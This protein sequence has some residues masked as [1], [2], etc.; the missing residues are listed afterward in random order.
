LSIQN[1]YD[2]SNVHFTASASLFQAAGNQRDQIRALNGLADNLV[3][4]S[5]FSEA[6]SL[7]TGI[8][9]RT[10]LLSGSDSLVISETLLLLSYTA[11]YN[12]RFEFALSSALRSL[13]IQTRYLPPNDPS[14][15]RSHF[16]L[17]TIY[18]R[19]GEFDNALASLSRAEEL[20]SHDPHASYDLAGTIITMGAVLDAKGDYTAAM[21]RYAR[22]MALLKGLRLEESLSAG[23]CYHYM[24]V[25]SRSLGR[26]EAAVEF[27]KNA[28]TVY[29]RLFGHNHLAVSGILGQLGDG[30][31]WIG[32]YATAR[33]YYE[34]GLRVMRVLL[35][36]GHSSI[37]EMER[38][39]ARLA[40]L[41]DDPDSALAL[42][43]HAALAKSKNLG[44]MHPAM[45]DIEEDFGDICRQRGDPGTALEHYRRAVEIKEKSGSPA[46]DLATVHEK[47]S[48]T[49]LQCGEPENAKKALHRAQLLTG[50]PDSRNPILVS[51]LARI[52]GDILRK[53]GLLEDASEAY[54]ESLRALAPADNE[55][56]SSLAR[57]KVRSLVARA[58]LHEEI[59]RK[60][61]GGSLDM[62]VSSYASAAELLSHLRRRYRA[63][64]SKLMLQEEVLPVYDAG[65]ALSAELYAKTGKE[66][67]KSRAFQF[68]EEARSVVLAEA[69][70]EAQAR[71]S[72][73]IPDSLL[74]RERRL[75]DAIVAAET[76][77]LKSAPGHESA[78]LSGL[79]R[80]LFAARRELENLQDQ[81]T[82]TVPSYRELRA[83][84]APAE[85][86]SLQEALRPGT[87]FLSYS[88][89][90]DTLF[91]FTV[92][93]ERST[94]RALPLPPFFDAS[95]QR[96]RTSLTTVDGRTYVATARSLY[97]TL[98]NPVE[99]EIS[100][101]TKLVI[102]P[103]GMLH[104][105][106][107]E[108]LL[109]HGPLP[110]AEHTDFTRLPY[111]ISTHEIVYALSGSLFRD[112]TVSAG[113][114]TAANRSFAGYA[115]VFPDSSQS[116]LLATARNGA[117][118]PDRSRSI[119][120]DG[121][122]FSEL[123]YSEEE[124]NAIAAA[125]IRKGTSATRFVEQDATKKNFLA[126][127]GN[128]S[129]VHIAT[130]GLV[131]E[132]S[133]SLSG[134]LFS[135]GETGE[136]AIL[137]AA[138]TQNVRLDADLLV[139]GSCESG[140]G[141]LANGEG[142]MAITRA[143]TIAGARNIALSLWKVYDKQ[144]SVLMQKFY[145]HVLDGEEYPEA[146]RHA[147][148]EMIS[149]RK[150][151][152]PLTWAGFVLQGR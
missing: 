114:S 16:Q 54:D 73:S 6:E 34:E 107:F 121:R 79:R 135:P 88:R 18:W 98:I 24:A 57:E 10:V 113:L 19:K 33:E 68:A 137:H 131:D 125:F 117:T 85:L 75:S 110:S 143:F 66:S 50:S 111:L 149:D 41:T 32:D 58:R 118:G 139:L 37:A 94:L 148:L 63:A 48:E 44:P 31:A 70:Q 100:K 7:L 65:L 141:K 77:L 90:G 29:E 82:R 35:G 86:G 13:D 11:N 71:R 105:I 40:M 103:D 53:E 38:K 109:H 130:H 30:Y 69:L 119:E 145:A 26:F 95:I 21:N 9:H 136:D 124:V 132:Q 101:S 72:G 112:A 133:P 4:M 102:V 59:Y 127:A 93:R 23:S 80:W 120:V 92:S 14:L 64:E 47:I 36:P 147:K 46:L 134:I 115:P 45:G 128:Y 28:L 126:T 78:E 116:L 97:G 2:S 17:G 151:A 83:K 140:M 67:Y 62:A 84:A 76:Q 91:L 150:T 1:S 96:L 108:V 122:V 89:V 60:E 81:L 74:L 152:F 15:A 51:A 87:M 123:K 142:V 20:Q 52:S 12:D 144:T 22:G 61:S 25:T 42:I 56:H 5:R 49:Y 106:P 43:S 8:I 146:L 39:L 3:R 27:E 55:F 129:M 138:E 99:R 104:Y